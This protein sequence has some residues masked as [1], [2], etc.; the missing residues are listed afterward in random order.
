MKFSDKNFVPG[1]FWYLLL[2]IVMVTGNSA[3]SNTAETEKKVILFLGNSLTAGYGLDPQE[4]FPALI[5]QEIDS[6]KWN[7]QVTNAGVSG[8]T[9][10]GGLRR[11]NW[12]L[13]RPIDVLILELGANDGLRGISPE[14]TAENLQDIIDLSRQKYPQI[15]IVIAGM[16]V[17]PNLGE[18]YTSRFRKIYPDLARKNDAT[19]IPFLLEGVA[20]N[21]DLNLQ[22]G[23]HPT[24][25][26]HQIV[27]KTV[28]KV[29]KPLLASLKE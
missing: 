28:W 2:L 14:V 24:A 22:D 26:G 9:S 1:N 16:E 6:L 21:P 18:S 25:A 11:I 8:E 23:I 15:K 27:A 5:Q 12:L 19:L 3:D 4:A 17:P 13:K 10:A 20:G 7:F 29:L